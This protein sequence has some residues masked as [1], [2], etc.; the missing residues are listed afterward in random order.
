MSGGCYQVSGGVR[1]SQL[2]DMLFLRVGDLG[3]ITDIKSFAL[4]QSAVASKTNCIPL[5]QP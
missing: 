4:Q 3:L 1:K 2:P 5:H